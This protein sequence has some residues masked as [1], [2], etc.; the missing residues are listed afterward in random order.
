M[1]L[2]TNQLATTRCQQR[3]DVMLDF[4]GKP[5]IVCSAAL[6]TQPDCYCQFIG[7]PEISKADSTWTGY[8]ERNN[9][10]HNARLFPKL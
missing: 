6:P 9:E 2:E 8:V 5:V 10:Q 4:L 7:R 3:G 1:Y